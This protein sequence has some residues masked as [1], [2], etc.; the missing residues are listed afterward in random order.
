[1]S[2]ALAAQEIETAPQEIEDHIIHVNELQKHGINAADI[3]KLT[4]AGISTCGMI[5]KLP[6]KV[7]LAIKGFSDGK[8]KI[9][10][11]K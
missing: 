9:V 10:F 5:Q 7:L 3:T 1:M 4:E 11:D 8:S 2:T 6:Q